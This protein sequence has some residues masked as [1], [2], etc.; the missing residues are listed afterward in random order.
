MV[1]DEATAGA[2]AAAGAVT[3]ADAAETVF[4]DVAF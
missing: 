4:F 2:A 3:G 1:I